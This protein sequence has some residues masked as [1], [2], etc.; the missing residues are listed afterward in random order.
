M[1]KN[2]LEWNVSSLKPGK[3][4][5]HFSV[6]PEELGISEELIK[7]NIECDIVLFK[8]GS[9][10]TLTGSAKF[11]LTLQCSRCLEEFTTHEEEN[12]SAHFV[13][14]ETYP[15]NQK[16]KLLESD[17]IVEYYDRDIIDL[18]QII[19]DAINL[20]IPMKPLC[21]E[22]CKGLCPICG[23]NLN[24]ETCNCQRE[25]IDPRWEPLKKLLKNDSNKK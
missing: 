4:K 14:R 9:E 21:K 15:N 20:S 8:K 1:K 5:Y 12:L 10:I 25:K 22:D 13:R 23:T 6:K 19:Y 17:I 24:K 18:T 16:E 11:S 7:E 2:Y 3:N